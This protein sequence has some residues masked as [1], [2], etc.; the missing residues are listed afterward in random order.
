MSKKAFALEL[1]VHDEEE[2]PAERHGQAGLIRD[3]SQPTVDASP[4]S[5]K[6]RKIL[7]RYRD[8]QPKSAI[9]L[10]EPARVSAI[11]ATALHNVMSYDDTVRE[12]HWTANNLAIL[13][14]G[15]I[16]GDNPI[17]KTVQCRRQ[18][19]EVTSSKK[20]EINFV[21]SLEN[22]QTIEWPYG[23]DITHAEIKR[24]VTD[25]FVD[26]ALSFESVGSDFQYKIAQKIGIAVF[27]NYEFDFK[28]Q[29]LYNVN[30]WDSNLSNDDIMK[31]FGEDHSVSIYTG[32]IIFSVE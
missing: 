12:V 21:D 18:G 8:P 26:T 16:G 28:D 15:E 23:L 29:D 7:D 5:A 1:L 17:T 11:P 4:P 19:E 10:S 24:K 2:N 25:P 14:N 3:P 27:R 32:E 6:K 13:T 30:D 20:I 22:I 9:K 31:L